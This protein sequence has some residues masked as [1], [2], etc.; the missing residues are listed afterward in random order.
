MSNTPTIETIPA[1]TVDTSFFDLRENSTQPTNQP[2]DEEIHQRLLEAQALR[3]SD[4]QTIIDN[5]K[6]EIDSLKTLILET[7]EIGTYQAGALKVTVKKGAVRLDT[8]KIKKNFPVETFPQL[9][10]SNLDS[11]SVRS[12]FSPQAL[13][14]YETHSKPSVTVA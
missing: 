5:A 6:T 10:T 2:T 11:K 13:E 9:Y 12:Q 8:A 7:H 14:A 3:I 4:L 1:A